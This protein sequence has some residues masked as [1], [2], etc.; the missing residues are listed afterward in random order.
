M[1][2][3]HKCSFKSHHHTSVEDGEKEVNGIWVI[4]RR[5]TDAD[6]ETIQGTQRKNYP[7][8]TGNMSSEN[9]R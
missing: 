8:P 1:V 4:T 6:Q 5:Q 7:G 9:R 3:I 2:L